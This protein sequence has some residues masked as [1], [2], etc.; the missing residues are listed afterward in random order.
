MIAKLQEKEKK[1]SIQAEIRYNGTGK[2]QNCPQS[3]CHEKQPHISLR[4][5]NIHSAV[6]PFNVSGILHRR[7]V[8]QNRLP[9]RGKLG[10]FDFHN[11]RLFT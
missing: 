1:R 9:D 3:R 7:F 8:H 11:L 6:F 2:N 5:R 10:A 4:L